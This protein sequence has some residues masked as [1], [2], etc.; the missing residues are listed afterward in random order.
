M[1]LLGFVLL[2]TG[3]ALVLMHRRHHVIA[4]V[5]AVAVAA[6]VLHGLVFLAPVVLVFTVAALVTVDVVRVGRR[7]PLLVFAAGMYGARRR[8]S[9]RRP[10]IE[11]QQGYPEPPRPVPAWRSQT[12]GQHR[13]V[14]PSPSVRYNEADVHNLDE[15][16][17]R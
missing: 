13:P 11:R 4:A 14:A 17:P 9:A 8:G 1:S 15:R 5:T 7:H 10:G 3:I 2:L 16:P 6:L 12:A